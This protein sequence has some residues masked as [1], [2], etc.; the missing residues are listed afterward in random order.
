MKKFIKDNSLSFVLLLL[1]FLSLFGLSSAGLSTYNEE[2]KSHKEE[3][4]S[5]AEYLLTPD[6]Y[7]AVFE[8]W[9]SEF[10][11]MWALVMLTIFLRQKGAPD[12]KKIKGKEDVD[13]S[14]RYS[15]L[16]SLSSS[17]NVGK[18]IKEKIYSNSLGLVLL[19]LFIFS[20]VLHGISGQ[21]VFNEEALTHG[22][23]IVSLPKYFIS[24]QFWFESFQNW[25]S[26]F[27][28]VG[29]LLVF[30]VFLRQRGSTESKPVSKPNYKTGK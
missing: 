15:I 19:A 9:E 3:Q 28:A 25:Q 11:Q 12:S 17:K 20:F 26:E 5:Y 14:S 24:S 29:S 22:E 30:S 1:F 21:K 13:T 18:A 27:L 10:L 4:V 8:N 2:Q 7:E 6:F 23:S 16:R